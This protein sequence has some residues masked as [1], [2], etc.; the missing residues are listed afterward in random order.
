MTDASHD[1]LGPIALFVVG[2]PSGEPS[3]AGFA[4]LVELVDNGLIHILDVEFVTKTNRTVEPVDAATLPDAVAPFVGAA[5]GLIDATDLSTLADELSDGMLAAVV[6]YEELAIIPALD[7]WEDE[8][9][10]ILL[11]GHLTPAELTDA[12]DATEN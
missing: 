12:L 3:P 10:T 8:G 4:K 11:E 5:S 6:V 9:A 7:A 2:F 1:H